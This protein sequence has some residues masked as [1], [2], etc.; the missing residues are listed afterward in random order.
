MV[1][2]RAVGP[3]QPRNVVWIVHGG[4]HPHAHLGWSPT[5]YFL[6]RVP[7]ISR[8][9]SLAS[10]KRPSTRDRMMIATGLARKIAAK[11]SSLR[12]S[13]SSVDAVGVKSVKGMCVG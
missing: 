2:Y 5:D 10:R 13:S 8:K 7:V 1:P 4:A 12:R 6:P 11:R 9:R 3:H